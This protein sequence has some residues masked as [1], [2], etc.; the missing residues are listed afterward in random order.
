M[1]TIIGIL[2]FLLTITWGII[3]YSLTYRNIKTKD[4]ANVK[5]KIIDSIAAYFLTSGKKNANYWLKDFL[6][7]KSNYLVV[8]E[9]FL[10]VNNIFKTT[11]RKNLK[12]FAVEI[13]LNHNIAKD[14]KSDDWYTK[15]RAIMYCYELG[16]NS[17]IKT[18][19]SFRN[20]SFLIVL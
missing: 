13:G 14:L 11:E 15:A 2:V 18:I 16:L 20:H 10:K 7:T 6:N 17:H 19:S 3:A 1:I 4:L 9:T 8:P 12:T 5:K